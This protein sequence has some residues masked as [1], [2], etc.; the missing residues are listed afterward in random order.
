[1]YQYQ[2]RLG[3]RLARGADKREWSLRFEGVL[4]GPMWYDTEE[5]LLVPAA[6]PT[7]AFVHRKSPFWIWNLR[8][9]RAFAA[10]WSAFVAVNNLLDENEHPIFIAIDETP[11]KADLR[12][13]NGA[14]GTSMPGREVVVGARV[15]F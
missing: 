11:T 14:A 6:E 1:M 15:K 9:E 2:G 7:R 4:R 12:F 3:T 5:S 13:Y 10:G 8:G